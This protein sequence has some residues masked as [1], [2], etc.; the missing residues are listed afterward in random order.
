MDLIWYVPVSWPYVEKMILKWFTF[1]LNTNVE[2]DLEIWH[3]L[4]IERNAMKLD[5]T[6][7]NKTRKE[8]CDVK[9]LV[10]KECELNIKWWFP[11]GI[12]LTNEPNPSVRE[13]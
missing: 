6:E 7:Q 5:S 9:N 1:G 4:K 13:V 10:D 2:G 3:I 8:T 12:F 11:N